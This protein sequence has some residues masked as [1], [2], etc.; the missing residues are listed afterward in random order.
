METNPKNSPKIFTYNNQGK[1]KYFAL[2]HIIRQVE[3]ATGLAYSELITTY[4]EEHLFY[5]ILKHVTTTKKAIC[6]AFSIPV[7][8]GCRYKRAL[9]KQ[10]RLVESVYRVFCPFTKHKARLITTNPDE[11]SKLLKSNTNQLKMF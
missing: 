8:A 4:K 11:F 10:G 2:N 9:E 6:T 1:D 3:N 7:E 5:V